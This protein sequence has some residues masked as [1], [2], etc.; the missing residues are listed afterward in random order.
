MPY[1]NLDDGFTEH[2]KADLLSDAA[3]RLQVAALC[4]C[5]KN[6]TDGLLPEHRVPRLVPRFRPAVVRELLRVEIWHP[7]GE[8]CGTK[9][10]PIGA[11][12]TY[13]I[14]DYLEWNKPREWWER[15]RK[16]EAER[17]AEY[18]RKQKLRLA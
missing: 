7:G 2:P 16:G 14:H 9:D 18:R 1:L 15:R 10:C 3:F 12:G 17:Q 13:V 8:G 4:Y 5:A 6:L 11:P